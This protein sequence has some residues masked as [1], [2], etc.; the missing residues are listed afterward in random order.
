MRPD[1]VILGKRL[2][3]TSSRFYREAS[4]HS[5]ELNYAFFFPELEQRIQE[6]FT[7]QGLTLNY[8][9]KTSRVFPSTLFW[10]KEFDFGNG[11]FVNRGEIDI[12]F[13]GEK[14]GSLFLEFKMR[15]GSVQL[16]EEPKL[17]LSAH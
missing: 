14:I 13:E 4:S 2:K 8:K 9:G 12:I 17:T 1:F 5:N 15:R 10:G 16:I 7:E 11:V 6:F 3:D